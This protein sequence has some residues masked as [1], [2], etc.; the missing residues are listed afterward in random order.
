MKRAHLLIAAALLS[1]GI[2]ASANAQ[3]SATNSGGLTATILSSGSPQY[4][5]ERA[6]PSVP[7]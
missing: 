7:I 2:S 5:P 1:L 4:D 6:G 3:P